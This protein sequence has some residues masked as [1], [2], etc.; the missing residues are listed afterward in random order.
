MVPNIHISPCV[1]D[2][3][4]VIGVP[5]LLPPLVEAGLCPGVI[6][7]KRCNHPLGRVIKEHAAHAFLSRKLKTMGAREEWLVLANRLSLIIVDRPA[8]ANPARRRVSVYA[9]HRSGF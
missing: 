2:K 4:S 6:R 9:L 8:R 5:G 7:V 1:G 3:D